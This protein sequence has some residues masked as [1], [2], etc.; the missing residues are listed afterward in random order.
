VVGGLV[1]TYA[2]ETIRTRQQTMRVGKKNT[3]V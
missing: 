3:V 2:P 1:G